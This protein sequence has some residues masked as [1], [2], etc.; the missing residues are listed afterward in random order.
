MSSRIKVGIIGCGAISKAY[1]N[2]CK[3]FPVLEIIACADLDPAQARAKADEFHIPKALSVQHLLVDP[4]VQLVVNLTIPVAHAEINRA[5]IAA[6]KH[7]FTEKPFSVSREE[8]RRVVEAARENRVLIGS[9]PDTFLGEAHQ[10]CRRL[11]DDGAIGEPIAATAF[12]ASHGVEMWHPNPGFFYQP[13]GGPMFD[14]GP[15]YL[16]ALVN[17]MGP[18]R[19]V[20]GATRIT[21]PER[22]VTSQPLHGTRIPVNTA[23]HLTGSVD[24][25]NDAIATV[26]MSFDLWGNRLPLLEIYGTEG[27]LSVPDPNAT[28]GKPLLR[29]SGEKEW[30]EMESA[31]TSLY[32]ENYGRGV[33]VADIARAIL[34]GRA[35][36]ASC[37]LAFHVVDAMQAFGESSAGNRHVMLESTCERPAA[38]PIGLAPGE[39][40]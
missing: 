32:G 2:G 3:N 5:A 7:V 9:A 15:Y 10:T 36:R 28:F 26:I 22:T 11:V 16:T 24:F 21:F 17:L 25:Q 18:M 35:H 6:G 23:T 20:C 40:D 14:M 1:L 33:G 39:L 29:K 19:R 13:G 31:H 38:L 37:E 8:G 30:R 34:T 27:T 4:D 12:M